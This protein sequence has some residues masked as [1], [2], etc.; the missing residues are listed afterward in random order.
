[1][2]LAGKNIIIILDL[3]QIELLP[4]TYFLVREQYFRGKICS[5]M[6]LIFLQQVAVE[7]A[8]QFVSLSN[9][10]SEFQISGVLNA[11]ALLASRSPENTAWIHLAELLGRVVSRIAK[12]ESLRGANVAISLGGN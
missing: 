7:V 11:P 9:T 4:R 3:I 5:N 6:D 1:M 10:R 12:G 8:E 2:L